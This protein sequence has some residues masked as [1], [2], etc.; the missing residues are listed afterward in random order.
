MEWAFVPVRLPVLEQGQRI[1]LRI[2]SGTHYRTGLRVVDSIAADAT[3]YRTKDE[4]SLRS[5]PLPAGGHRSLYAPDGLVVNSARGE[6]FFLWVTGIDSP[7]AMRQWGQHATAFVGLGHFDDAD[8]IDKR[9]RLVDW[10]D[11]YN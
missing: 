11:S 10:R 2:E 9:F 5:L 3:R 8:L 6:R 4:N 1:A 7:G